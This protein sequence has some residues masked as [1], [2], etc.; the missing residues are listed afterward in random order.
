MAGEYGSD[1]EDN[2][3]PAA[4][5]AD[6]SKQDL[7]RPAA[8]PPQSGTI[9]KAAGKDAGHSL[10]NQSTKAAEEEAVDYD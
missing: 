8:L 2:D 5:A 4:A 6:G 9:S 7:R 10:D 1:E 3:S